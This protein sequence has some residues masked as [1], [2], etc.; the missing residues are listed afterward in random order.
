VDRSDAQF[1]IALAGAHYINKMVRLRE[2]KH[3]PDH[4]RSE[5]AQRWQHALHK[6][7]PRAHYQGHFNITAREHMSGVDCYDGKKVRRGGGEDGKNGH[8]KTYKAD[9]L[10]IHPVVDGRL[11][12]VA[13]S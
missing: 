1:T 4:L 5:A 7:R 6:L 2:K 8:E 12:D 10:V 3:E 11:K 9:L 13:R